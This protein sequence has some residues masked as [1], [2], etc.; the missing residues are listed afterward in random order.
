MEIRVKTKVEGQASAEHILQTILKNR[1]YLTSKQQTEFLHPP[2]P[3]LAYLLQ[4]SGLKKSYLR[5][6][7]QLLDQHLVLGHDICVFGD[8]DADGVTATAVMWLALTAYAKKTDSTSRIL[9]FIPDRHR[10]GY[11]L[12]DLAVSEVLDGSAFKLTQIRDFAPQLIISVDTGIVAHSSIDRFRKAKR[13]ILLTDHHQPEVTLPKA[14]A[15]LHTTATSGAGVAWLF[16]YFLL[17]EQALALLDLATIG[18]VGDMMPLTSLNRSLVAAG[19]HALTKTK[20]P[21]LLAM[22]QMMGI[23]QKPITTYDLSFGLAPR[24]NA[25]GRI[26]NPLDALRLLCTH[27]S[28]LAGELAVKIESH[29]QDRQTL[30]DQALTQA[31]AR[32]STHKIIVIKGDY[33]EGV[34]GLV[35]GKLVEMF[36]RPA[37]VM[38]V[39]DN[40]VKGSARSLPGINITDLLRSLPTPF[41]GLGG[42]A[43]A[44]GFSLDVSQVK[45]FTAKLE[46]L[47]NRLIP[48]SA[49]VKTEHADLSLSLNNSSLSLAK[50]L[51]TLEPFGIG[52]LK[53]KFLFT[54]LTVL[55]DRALGSE[56]K[57]HKLTVEQE[58]IT[59]EVLLFNTKHHHPL[60]YLKSLIC[61]LDINLWRDKQSLQLIASYVET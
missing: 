44:A 35:A 1:G 23:T 24:I 45:T 12:S 48:D 19:L 4:T 54:D 60:K 47:A 36:H 14:S 40:L 50:L 32:K 25:S 31:V 58:G 42:H 15:I 28:H 22:K 21:G 6:A 8:Y 56:G 33:H 52:N 46:A 10:H 38:S 26:Y 43:Q 27:D 41:L 34:I 61:T 5:Q 49:L 55:E 20:R 7:Q 2:A 18:I 37:V 30:T 39:H 17:G 59:R 16:A 9:P 11:G 13:D 3:T 57:H 29:N 53:P 51:H